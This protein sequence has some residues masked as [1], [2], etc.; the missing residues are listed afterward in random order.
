[1]LLLKWYSIFKVEKIV[2]VVYA[3]ERVVKVFISN[4]GREY[5]LIRT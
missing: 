2:I 1:M 4:C 5:E 3:G